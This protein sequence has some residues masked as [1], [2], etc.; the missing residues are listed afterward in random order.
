MAYFYAVVSHGGFTVASKV[1]DVPKSLL[2]R[3]VARLE[4][5]LG[6]R[7]INRSSR[8]FA[9]TDIGQQYALQCQRML[10]QA[11]Y[12]YQIVNTTLVHPSGRLVVSA[13]VMLTEVFLAPLIADF[14]SQ[15]QDVQITLLAV[16]REVS[17]IEKGVDIAIRNEFLPLKDSDLHYRVLHK[18]RDILVASPDFVKEYAPLKSIDQLSKLPTLS[19][20]ND[21]E[22]RVWVLEHP[23]EGQKTI[24]IYPRVI[25]NNL[26]VLTQA[27]I[28][29]LGVMIMPE[30][31]Y[32]FMTTYGLQQVFWGWQ[33]QESV[34]HAVFS[35]HKGQSLAFRTFMDFLTQSFQ[36]SEE[37]FKSI[38]SPVWQMRKTSA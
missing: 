21:H 6:I 20:S 18:N 15:Y 14:L 3:R 27:A 30:E 7:L 28:N 11:E 17:P 33:S 37:L 19:S 29:G 34:L 32:P 36:N 1:L 35:S 9:V 26:M 12:A 8:Q 23:E 38:G 22:K 31:I 5:S 2:S 25:S 4:E 24:P 16:N 13:P 10:E